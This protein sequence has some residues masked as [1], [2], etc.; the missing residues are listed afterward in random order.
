MGETKEQVIDSLGP[1]LDIDIKTTK[2][3]QRET[4]KYNQVRANAYGTKIIIE[5]GIVIG[6]E[7]K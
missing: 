4:L 3:K 1:P 7:V 5:N 6:W 2:T